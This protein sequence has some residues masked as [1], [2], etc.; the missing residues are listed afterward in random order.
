MVTR[1][2]ENTIRFIGSPDN[3]AGPEF[4]PIIQATLLSPT[5]PS[6]PSIHPLLFDTGASSTCL[7]AGLYHFLGLADWD[8]GRYRPI[9]AAG[10]TVPSYEYDVTLE[11]FGKRF[12]CPIR[13][14]QMTKHERFS[15]LL[16]RHTIFKEFGFGFWERTRELYVTG[17][18]NLP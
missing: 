1:S 5:G 14:I 15:G 7:C 3:L 17:P 9:D 16:G 10:G 6:G 4:W 2:F 12:T 11:V 8:V 13:L 18:L